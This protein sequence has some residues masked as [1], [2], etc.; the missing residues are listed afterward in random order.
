MPV[1]DGL[2]DLERPEGRLFRHRHDLMRSRETK[3]GPDGLELGRYRHGP[4]AIRW[5]TGDGLSETLQALLNRRPAQL[6]EVVA[7]LQRL[8]CT[9]PDCRWALVILGAS[10]PPSSFT[11]SLSTTDRG[12]LILHCEHV[13]QFAVV[14]LRPEV[15][16]VLR[17]DELCVDPQTVPGLADAALQNGPDVQLAGPSHGDHGDWP[18]N[19]NADVRA[20]TRRPS[21]LGNASM[22]S[23]AMP[24]QKVLLLGIGAHVGERATRQWTGSPWAS[25]A[26]GVSAL[27]AGHVQELRHGLIPL[28]CVLAERLPDHRLCRP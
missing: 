26:V 3:H 1:S 6:R 23:S 13:I 20:T 12:N 28:P 22:S 9:P 16:A 27:S 2:V 19:W 15:I 25:Y 17:V 5:S 7:A 14:S 21:R 4:G 18:L 8:G 10:C 11:L 24:S